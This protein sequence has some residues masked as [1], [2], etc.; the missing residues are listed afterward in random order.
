[1]TQ[2]NHS[3]C[4]FCGSKL[5]HTFV[6]LGMSPLCESYVSDGPSESDG[7]VL[8][9]TRPCVREMFL[10]TASGIRFAGNIF[11]ATTHIFHPIPT[12]GLRMQRDTPIRWSSGL[13]SVSKVW[14]WNWP[15]TMAICSNTLSKNKSQSWVS[16]PRR[17]SRLSR[18]KK[19][20][21][22][23]LSS[24]GGRRPASSLPRA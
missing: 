19:V 17:T 8:P 2:T 3:G 1:M 5:E 18:L 14:W 15:A 9:P 20:Y 11:S 22:L 23:S 21:P 24:S 7:T 4:R 13:P 16:S 12:P 10:G 6:D